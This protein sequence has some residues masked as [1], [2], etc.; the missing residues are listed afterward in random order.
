[1]NAP[2][3]STKVP[4]GVTAKVLSALA[5]L[6]SGY[7]MMRSSTNA[8]YLGRARQSMINREGTVDSFTINTGLYDPE[9]PVLSEMANWWRLRGVDLKNGADSFNAWCQ[10]MFFW[11]GDC[12]LPLTA[13]IGSLGIGFRDELKTIFRIVGKYV[14]DTNWKAWIPKGFD[15][16]AKATGHT[17]GATYKGL[18]VSTRMLSNVAR[19]API[20]SAILGVLAVLTGGKF[21]SVLNGDNQ[22]S[23]LR[24]DFT[25]FYQ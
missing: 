6:A 10:T 3:F 14:P 2:G 5:A 19:K 13:L 17:M 9:A 7:T 16:T 8:D 12:W 25:K 24:D 20:P 18:R 4:P 1:M 15:L 21:F 23:T 22:R 11:L